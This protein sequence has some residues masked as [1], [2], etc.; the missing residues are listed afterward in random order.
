[1]RGPM[2]TLSAC[3]VRAAH[4]GQAAPGRQSRSR[5]PTSTSTTTYRRRRCSS[6]ASRP[7][8]THSWPGPRPAHA[9][10]AGRRARDAPAAATGAPR[11]R[12]RRASTTRSSPTTS[13]RRWRSFASPDASL[14]QAFDDRRRRSPCQLTFRP[15]TRS[16]TLR[17]TTTSAT[18]PL[19]PASWAGP[20]SCAPIPTGLRSSAAG[21]R[22]RRR[23]TDTLEARGRWRREMRRLVRWRPAPP[24]RRPR[25]QEG[26]LDRVLR[27]AAARGRGSPRWAGG[28]GVG[29]FR[30]R[31]TSSG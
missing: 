31:L 14:R 12:P 13:P 30:T 25:A 20:T 4:R 3:S 26:W 15:P 17:R 16:S 1:M 21:R 6:K 28:Y 22:T 18:R 10:S 8:S 2:S 19:T 27:G 24:P 29:R 9:T 7:T 23:S 11:A 5:S